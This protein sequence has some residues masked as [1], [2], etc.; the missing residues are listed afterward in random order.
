MLKKIISGGQTGA[1]Y[2]GL[3]AGRALK[4]ETGG[5]AP[6]GWITEAGEK[7]KTLRGLG[8]VES[9]H[10]GY[11]ARTLANVRDA[12]A[13]VVF[14]NLNS[15]GTKLTIRLCKTEGKPIAY[16]PSSTNLRAFLNA[17][18]VEVLNVAGNRE[19]KN[20]GIGERVYDVLVGALGNDVQKGA[21][22]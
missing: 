9:P 16:N 13:T 8:L 15:P 11:N 19:S 4:I 5:T 22:G 21:I 7:E 12:D 2:A 6:R 17:H 18:Q 1:D 14:G 10:A 20:K 3:W